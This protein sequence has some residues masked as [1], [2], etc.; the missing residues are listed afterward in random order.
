MT[1]RKIISNAVQEYGWH[2]KVQHYS[3]DIFYDKKDRHTEKGDLVAAHINV[4]RRYLNAGL[5]ICP[6]TVE[7]WVS[8][9][10]DTEY[11][12]EIIAHE[13]SHIATQHFFDVA[14]ACYKD[15]G[16]MTDAWETCTTVI[17]KLVY[18]LALKKK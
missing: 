7:K 15:E 11:I 2:L 12:K 18:R 6:S 14:I 16:E 9:K 13:I 17:G 10:F 5:H 4:D 1:L 8:K 3:I